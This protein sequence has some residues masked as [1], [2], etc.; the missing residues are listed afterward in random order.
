[1]IAIYTPTEEFLVFT[2]NL[3]KWIAWAG[4]FFAII[5]FPLS[6]IIFGVR[7]SRKK[8]FD[9][10]LFARKISL[11]SCSPFVIGLILLLLTFI[12]TWIVM[13]ESYKITY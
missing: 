5:S 6:C 11:W 10:K 13:W 3:L 2:I 9:K 8:P 4:I 7:G 12:A 1:M